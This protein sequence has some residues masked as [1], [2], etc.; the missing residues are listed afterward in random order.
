MIKVKELLASDILEANKELSAFIQ[1]IMNKC[2]T[3]LTKY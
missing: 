2:A 3:T 1:I